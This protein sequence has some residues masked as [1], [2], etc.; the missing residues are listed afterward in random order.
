MRGNGYLGAY[1]Q[2]LTLA[3]A[4]ATS[5]S[6]N[7]TITLSSAY[8]HTYLAISLVSMCRNSVNTASGLKLLSP[9]CSP[10][11][12]SYKGDKILVIWLSG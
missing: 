5:L 12:I 10:T 8:C 4:P 1:G 6:Y 11:T 3:F 7:R 9:S 2:N